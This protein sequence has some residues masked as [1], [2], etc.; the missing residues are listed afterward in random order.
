MLKYWVWLA[1]LPGLKGPARLA[2][3]RHFG[4]PEDLF[5]ADQIGRASCRERV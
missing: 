4:S 3:L 1:E 2:L 5:F